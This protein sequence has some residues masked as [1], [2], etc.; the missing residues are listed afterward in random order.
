MPRPMLPIVCRSMV[1]AGEDGPGRR[2]RR[3]CRPLAA[4][5]LTE[6]GPRSKAP[7]RRS[8]N[9]RARRA[10]LG[11]GSLTGARH[12]RYRQN[13]TR[14]HACF[15]WGDP[16]RPGDRSGRGQGLGGGPVDHEIG[17]G[18]PVIRAPAFMRANRDRSDGQ[19]TSTPHAPARPR[20]AARPRQ[21]GRGHEHPARRRRPAHPLARARGGPKN[22]TG[23]DV[24]DPLQPKVV[25][26]TDLPHARMR[27]NS[28][29]V[30]GDIMA[31][32]YQTS[33]GLK[34]PGSICS[35]SATP[36]KPRRIAFRCLGAS[37]PGALTVSGSSMASTST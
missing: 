13:A 25:V 22:F 29:E 21:D 31:V 26:Q 16:S 23:V 36:E 6:C 4:A 28:L 33:P 20:H 1:P 34:P 14:G 12:E 32:A 10:G 24:T 2:G 30:V 9:A 18:R 19:G 11:P 17:I 37:I 8:Q 3:A 5:H 7:R 15:F 35:T 27:S